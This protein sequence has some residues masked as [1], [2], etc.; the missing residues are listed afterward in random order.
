[1][2]NLSPKQVENLTAPGAYDDGEGLR[3]VVKPTGR[4]Y[5]FLRFQLD[6][7]RRDMSLGSYPDVNLKAARIEASAKRKQLMSGDDPLAVRDDERIAK[8]EAQRVKAARGRTFAMLA[9]EYLEAHGSGWSDGI[10]PPPGRPGSRGSSPTRA[11]TSS[12]TRP[13]APPS[14]AAGAR[15]SPTRCAGAAPSSG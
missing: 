15:S 6:G 13:A 5:W 1:M 14:P 7:K 2:G 12:S 10:P 8:R 11:S 4:K 9:D 3:L